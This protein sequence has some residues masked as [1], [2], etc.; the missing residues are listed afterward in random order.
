MPA[1]GQYLRES[2]VSSGG[3]VT[4]ARRDSGAVAARGRCRECRN[5][6]SM[7]IIQNAPRRV[8][9]TWQPPQS[10]WSRYRAPRKGSRGKHASCACSRRPTPAQEA[11]LKKNNTRCESH[12][13]PKRPHLL[14]C[15]IL[16]DR[17]LLRPNAKNNG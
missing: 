15:T 12:L 5:A 17:A 16:L 4:A 8:G 13:Y 7:T 1:S 3:W 2:S 11:E 14:G 6:A 9:H 10:P